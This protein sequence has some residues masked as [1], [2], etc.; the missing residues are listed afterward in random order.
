[1][2]LTALAVVLYSA[3]FIAGVRIGRRENWIAY[4]VTPTCLGIILLR[5]FFRFHP[6]VEY[7]LFPWDWYALIRTAYW[8]PFAFMILGVAVGRFKA[9][10]ARAPIEI[11]AG[12]LFCFGILQIWGD[13][14]ASNDRLGGKPRNGLCG[15]TSS[16]SCGA[17]ASATLLAQHNIYA[18]EREMADLCTTG[19]M[20]GTDE[21]EVCMGLRAKLP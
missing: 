20:T 6:D 1:M 18:T 13:A 11:L 12:V 9:V 21:F 2:L 19:P 15:Q 8:W 10:L 3:A 17:A 5:V 16:Y 4:T 7:D 14:T